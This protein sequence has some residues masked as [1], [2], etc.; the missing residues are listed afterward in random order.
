MQ[1]ALCHCEIAICH[2][3][4]EFYLYVYNYEL[5][6]HHCSQLLQLDINYSI[7]RTAKRNF[8]GCFEIS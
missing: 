2:I 8:K 7:I 4:Y 1:Y 5:F 6:T 3:S